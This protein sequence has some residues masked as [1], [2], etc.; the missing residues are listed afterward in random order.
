MKMFFLDYNKEGAGVP[1]D[2]PPK[3]GLVLFFDLFA[4]E[5]T[6]LIKLNIFFIL[7]CV[8]IIT[9]G[10]A[11]GAMTAVTIRMVQ[12]EPS[13]L[14]Y[15]FR[16]AFKK[17]WK[18]SFMSGILAV[19]FMFVLWWIMKFYMHSDGVIYNLMIS[20]TVVIIVLLGVSCIYVYPMIVK[21]DLPLRTI[22]KNAFLLGIAYI[23]HSFPTFLLCVAIFEGSILFIPFTLPIILLFTFSFISFISSFCA[24][25]GIKKYIIGDAN[26]Y[27]SDK[28]AV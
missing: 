5:F 28:K 9:I 25:P 1:K 14:F 19:T 18:Y 26:G 22:L 3:E 6:S 10:P 17:N 16:E 27:N 7:S 21:V 24:W 8:P 23:K 20:F 11:I 2:A 12:D 13:D 15:D 4:R